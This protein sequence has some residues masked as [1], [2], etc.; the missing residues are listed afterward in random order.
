MREMILPALSPDVP[1][2]D[3]P[4]R[5]DKVVV[6][7]EPEVPEDLVKRLRHGAVELGTLDRLERTDLLVLT[8]ILGKEAQVAQLQNYIKRQ[9]NRHLSDSFV[10]RLACI[11]Y[12]TQM[13]IVDFL[14]VV[15]QLWCECKGASNLL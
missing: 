10:M 2:E 7:L 9:L 14:K 15:Y 5:V 12:F 13:F 11:T 3:V 4:V 1:V 6:V 8:T